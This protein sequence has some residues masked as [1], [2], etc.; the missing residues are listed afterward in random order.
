MRLSI[1]LVS[2]LG[3]IALGIDWRDCTGGYAK[4]R[5]YVDYVGWRNT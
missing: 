3:A 5:W 1:K 4:S 2:A